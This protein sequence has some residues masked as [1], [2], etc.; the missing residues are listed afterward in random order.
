MT[1]MKGKY[2]REFTAQARAAYKNGDQMFATGMH[3]EPH[4]MRRPDRLLVGLRE[5]VAAIE[6]E[7]WVHIETRNLITSIQLLFARKK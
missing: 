7:G 2:L 3:V 4:G 6:N 1:V 5:A